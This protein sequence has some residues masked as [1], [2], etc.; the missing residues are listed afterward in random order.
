MLATVSAILSLIYIA[1]TVICTSA[2]IIRAD[3]RGRCKRIQDYKKGNFLIHY[4]AVVPLYF[5]AFTVA[6][7][8]LLFASSKAISGMVG[9]AVLSFNTDILLPVMRESVIFSI[10][11]W[12]SIVVAVFNTLLFSVSLFFRRT[13]LWSRR[14]RIKRGSRD[15]IVL[16]GYGAGNRSVLA[17]MNRDSKKT[18]RPKLDETDVL[19]LSQGQDDA[20]KE[21]MHIY[22]AA[23][24]EISA[25]AELDVILRDELVKFD[26]RHVTVIIQSETDAE[27][28]RFSYQAADLAHSLGESV[29][30]AYTE[31]ASGLD[32]YVFNEKDNEAVYRRIIRRSHG[33]VHTLSRYKMLARDFISKHPI[34]AYI[35]DSIDTDAAALKEGT[36]IKVHLIGFGKANKQLFSAFVQ[37]NKYLI[38]K[39][40]GTLGEAIFDYHIFDKTNATEDSSFNHTYNHYKRW[41]ERPRENNGDY[42]ELPPEPANIITH[43]RDIN[44][45]R[46]L[47]ELSDALGKSE[48]SFNMIIISLGDDVAA[49]DLAEKISVLLGEEAAETRS[50][51]FVRVRDLSLSKEATS[52]EAG[53]TTVDTF[54]DLASLLTYDKIVNP[55]ADISAKDRH[56]CYSLESFEEGLTEKD[57]K[58]EALNTWLYRW[59]DI[60]RESNAF[61]I[62]ALRSRFHLLG[63]E[64][65]PSDGTPDDSEEFM[66]DYTSGNG[67]DYKEDV[68]NGKR[69]VDY[70][71]KYHI[72]GTPRTTLAICEHARWNAYYICRGFVPASKTELKTEGK[73]KLMRRRKHINIASFDGLK[74][75]AKWR[76][77]TEGISESDADIIKYDYQLMDDAI[78]ILKRGGYK[79]VKIK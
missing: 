6:G 76:I 28:L 18:A 78:W 8:S 27:N 45:K 16:V 69:I 58:R 63:Y 36:D 49:L 77:E 38:K 72:E 50:K 15:V 75:Y 34:T 73:A 9:V 25:D 19:V 17:S 64:I 57:V 52:H 10:A 4:V 61:A 44:E 60:Q 43:E 26:T 32:T 14:W 71:K 24:K 35:K 47:N 67:I 3:R 53:E 20:F 66:R 7:E 74:S 5:A 21:D 51:I 29:N 13:A 30:S 37:N 33:T 46:F 11:V 2:S 1:V 31:K 42:F 62:L 54:G 55:A 41:L 70:N 79:V 23:Y 56:L 39:S 65:M 48:K 12:T 40:D 22:R 59:E 68:I